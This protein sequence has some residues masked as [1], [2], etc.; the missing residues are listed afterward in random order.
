MGSLTDSAVRASETDA[1]QEHTGTDVALVY[2]NP[3]RRQ[4]TVRLTL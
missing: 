3:L 4:G 1:S 2:L